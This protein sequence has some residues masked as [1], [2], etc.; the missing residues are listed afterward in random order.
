MPLDVFLEECV[1][2]MFRQGVC[3]V[4]FYNKEWEGIVVRAKKLKEKLVDEIESTW[5]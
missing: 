5:E 3:F 2:D 4:V 1:A